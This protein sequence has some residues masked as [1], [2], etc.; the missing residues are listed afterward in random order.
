MINLNFKIMKKS[1][2]ILII[3][4]SLN[5]FSQTQ[6]ET[7]GLI[8]PRTITFQKKELRLN[9]FGT[10]SKMW[11]DVYVQTLFLTVL[12]Q[13]AKEILNSDTEMAIRIQVLF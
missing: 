13:D 2:L 6:F 8:I 11:I 4:F 9:G 10:R 7:E 5:T 1:F 12:S 3:L